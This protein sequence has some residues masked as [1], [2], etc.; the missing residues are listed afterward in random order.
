MR[1]TRVVVAAAVGVLCLLPAA[2]RAQEARAAAPGQEPAKE[3]KGLGPWW[4]KSSLSYNPVPEQLLFHVTS[5]LSFSDSRGNTHGT[6]FSTGNEVV[7]RKRRVTSRST[8]DFRKTDM[9]Y[10]LGGGSADYEMSTVREHVEYDLRAHAVLVAGIEHAR[11]T[12][13]FMDKRL[14]G[15][16]GAGLTIIDTPAHKFDI[17]GGL[18]YAAYRFDREAMM[19]IDPVSVAALPTT[20]PGS[21]AV[22][23]QEAWNWK[24]SKQ[25]TVHQA[26]SYMEYFHQDLGEL[27]TF[28]ISA[29][30]P[31]TKHLSF[32]PKYSLRKEDNI[33]IRAL[34]I[35]TLDRTFG[36]GIRLAF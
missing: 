26:G 23:V 7:L 29:D 31:V 14:T 2:A 21:G 3:G 11:N 19:Q 1:M 17:I 35:Q 4:E 8:V 22:L 6:Q 27:W 9:V 12:L 24:F 33:Y 15:Y 34:D 36:F 28:D 5:D 30:V 25:L 20:T 18:G 32:A 16:T 10:G 13:Y